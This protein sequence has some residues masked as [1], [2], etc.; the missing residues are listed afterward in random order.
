MNRAHV[1][2]FL[3]GAGAYYLFARYRGAITGT[4]WRPISAGRKA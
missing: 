4:P 2:T 1:V 3:A